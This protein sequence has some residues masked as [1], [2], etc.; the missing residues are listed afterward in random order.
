MNGARGVPESTGE[1]SRPRGEPS[2]NASLR[3]VP[4]LGLLLLSLAGCAT[5]PRGALQGIIEIDK[6]PARTRDWSLDTPPPT[7][8]SDAPAEIVE[9][10][11]H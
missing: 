2:A 11:P 10:P 4:V 8:P 3:S 1:V 6:Q 5:T 7:G 9:L